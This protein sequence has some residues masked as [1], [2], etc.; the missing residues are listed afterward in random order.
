MSEKQ[1]VEPLITDF[2]NEL[3]DELYKQLTDDHKRWGN[4]WLK[5]TRKGQEERIRKCFDN[6]FDQFENAGVPIP[7]LKIIGNAMI[8]WIR[9]KHFE[10]FSNGK[11]K[12]IVIPTSPNI[13]KVE[14]SSFDPKTDHEVK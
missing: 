5:R 12:N 14:I 3:K 8:A 7:W 11:E 9:E 4:T 13:P 1:N 2:L 10:L 6:Y